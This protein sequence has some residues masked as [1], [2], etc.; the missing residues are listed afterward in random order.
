MFLNNVILN[1]K[2]IKTL[3]I[4]CRLS[5]AFLNDDCI[6]DLHSY[7]R[8]DPDRFSPENAKKIPAIAFPAFGVGARRCPGYHFSRYEAMIAVS[9]L[10][11]KYEFKPAF[12]TNYFVEPVYGFI[13]KPETEIWIKL[14]KR[15]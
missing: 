12:E 3:L 10:V 8:F 5:I 6:H 9:I 1:Q 4:S 7:F 11:R 15:N 2:G 13:T 14:R